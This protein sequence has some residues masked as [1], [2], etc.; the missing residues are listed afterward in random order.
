LFSSVLFAVL[1]SRSCKAAAFKASDCSVSNSFCSSSVLP[2]AINI[3]RNTA[4][5]A[6]S[7]RKSRIKNRQSITVLRNSIT[8]LNLAYELFSVVIYRSDVVVSQ[9]RP[10]LSYQFAHRLLPFT[11]DLL[12]KL[13][14]EG[15]A[16]LYRDNPAF[17]PPNKRPNHKLEDVAA[18]DPVGTN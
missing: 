15:K 8:F 5:T 17:L 6:L 7:A 9:H 14:M 4:V 11:F 12:A 18:L 10:P 13:S 2:A 1:V 16:V 3:P